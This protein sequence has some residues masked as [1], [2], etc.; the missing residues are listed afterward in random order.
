MSKKY[1]LI[2]PVVVVTVLSIIGSIIFSIIDLFPISNW[3]IGL[4]P[5]I[6]FGIILFSLPFIVIGGILLQL[7]LRK[8]VSPLLSMIIGGICGGI[9]I[10]IIFIIGTSILACIG[11]HGKCIENPFIYIITTF[12]SFITPNYSS[13]FI[14]ATI[15]RFTLALPIAIIC[16]VISGLITWKTNK[17]SN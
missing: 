6:I 2:I 5:Y 13:E 17:N 12:T 8:I 7:L 14:T 4:P 1:P 15:N 16:G 10:I 9:T 11:S 3:N